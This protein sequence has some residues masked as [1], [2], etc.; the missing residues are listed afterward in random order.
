MYG[1]ERILIKSVICVEKQNHSKVL[2]SSEVKEKPFVL[3]FSDQYHR[4]NIYFKNI[5]E[6][7]TIDLN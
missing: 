1:K 3:W 4:R 5:I 2:F 6:K 7:K